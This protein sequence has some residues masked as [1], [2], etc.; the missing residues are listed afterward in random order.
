MVL[1]ECLVLALLAFLVWRLVA[2]AAG[3]ASTVSLA[4]APASPA[5]AESP[6]PDLPVAEAPAPAGPPPGLNLGAGFWRERLGDLNRDQVG[7]EQLE[8]TIAHAA[9]ATVRRYLE[10]VV[11]PAIVRAERAD[12]G[13]GREGRLALV[14]GHRD[15]AVERR[16]V[17]DGEPAHLDVAVQVA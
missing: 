9:M 2:G 7:L 17:L 5:M 6:L 10:S 14:L 3:H 11:V 16:P 4:T 1:A 15:V 12:R 13:A 8:W